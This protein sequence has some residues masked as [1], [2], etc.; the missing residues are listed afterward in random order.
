MEQSAADVH[1]HICGK[2][3][4]Q[5]CCQYDA[6]LLDGEGTVIPLRGMV[7][8]GQDGPGCI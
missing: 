1:A 7:R 8:R 6:Y 4:Y 2:E 3:G 5:I